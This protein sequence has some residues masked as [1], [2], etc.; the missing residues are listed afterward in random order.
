MK[1]KFSKFKT[2]NLG[3]GPSNKRFTGTRYFKDNGFSQY[4]LSIIWYNGYKD[5]EYF[6]VGKSLHLYNPKEKY[7][8]YEAPMYKILP[9]MHI[10]H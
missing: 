2:K 6:K 9:K 4:L 10:S 8:F 5:R 1:I 7:A 3:T